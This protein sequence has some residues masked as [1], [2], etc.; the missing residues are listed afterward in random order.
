MIYI[1]QAPR[2]VLVGLDSKEQLVCLDPV[3]FLEHQ[4]E[5]GGLELQVYK[6]QQVCIGNSRVYFY[7]T[8]IYKEFWHDKLHGFINVNNVHSVPV[9]QQTL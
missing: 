4:A 3:D 1:K 2:E 9:K 6:E 7:D 5:V 8:N